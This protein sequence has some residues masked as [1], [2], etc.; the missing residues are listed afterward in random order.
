M[1]RDGGPTRRPTGVPSGQGLAGVPRSIVRGDAA[2]AADAADTTELLAA[3]VDGVAELPPEERR[4]VEA[5]L[6]ESSEARAE[7]ASV[8]ALLARLRAPA[9]EGEAPDWAAMEQAIQRAV[10]PGL[11]RPWWRRPAWIVPTT[12]LA[13]AG[14]M[15]AMWLA[16]VSPPEMQPDTEATAPDAAHAATAHDTVALW[17]DGAE[18]DV[19]P[20]VA[21]ATLPIELD[22]A[23]LSDDVVALSERL[24]QVHSEPEIEAVL[25][26]VDGTVRLLPT[27]NLAWVDRL[28]DDALERAERWLE[29]PVTPAVPTRK[30]G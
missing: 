5:R 26:A 18:V 15:L 21:V 24:A 12:A 11:P 9:P 2:D 16:P 4:Q 23:D 1:S 17:L 22:A 6:A 10:G 7:A 3:Y 25:D 30:G 13:A 20:S 28:D 8:R 29:R 19:D 14:A 27:E